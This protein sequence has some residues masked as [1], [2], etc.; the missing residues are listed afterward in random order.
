MTLLVWGLGALAGAKRDASSE[1]VPASR[2]TPNHLQ[3]GSAAPIDPFSA[4]S[5][6][7]F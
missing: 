4:C 2:R 5:S 7:G 6:H 3:S 1:Y